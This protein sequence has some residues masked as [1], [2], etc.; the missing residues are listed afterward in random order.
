PGST[1]LGRCIDVVYVVYVD[2]AAATAGT[3]LTP[4]SPLLKI[5]DG[6]NKAIMPAVDRLY[7]HVATGTYAEQVSTSAKDHPLYIV[8]APGTIIKP[9]GGDALGVSNGASLTVRGVIASSTGNGA[10]CQGNSSRFTAYQS[11]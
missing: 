1:N 11:Q 4:T 6:L 9:G 7:V 10:N 2:G 3:G 8:G 5:Q